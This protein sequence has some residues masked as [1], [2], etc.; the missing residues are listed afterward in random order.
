[1]VR[2][3]DCLGVG[4]RALR[5]HTGRSLLTTLG[6]VAGV[7]AVICTMSIGA[8]AE[9]EVAERL[10][11][12]GANLLMVTPGAA[13]PTGVR[14]E[15]GLQRNLTEADAAA[16]GAEIAG[17]E[18]AA[19]L[20]ARRLQIIA[21]NR[22]WSTLVAGVTPAYLAEREWSADEG[23]LFE[24]DDLESAARLAIIGSDVADALF[25]G[26]TAV[27][28]PIRI[29]A[30]PATV[31]AVLTRKGVGA[32]GRSQ[33]DVVFVPLSMARTRLLGEANG[34]RRNALDLIS[35]KLAD[36]TL[37]S[38]AKS[39]IETLLRQRHRLL[40]D[41]PDDFAVENPADVL[42][43][44]AGATRAL[45]WLLFG[46]AAVSLAVGGISLMNIMLVSVGERTREFG[47]RM[48]VGAGRRDLLLQMLVETISLALA[49]GLVGSL[50]GIAASL[51]IASQAEWRVSISTLA[52]LMAWG[53][54]GAVGLVFGLYP[55]YRASR[56]DPIEALR[57][58]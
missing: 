31:V 52:V 48:A 37:L 10:R 43:A 21:G 26:R 25:E 28:K 35:I 42:E 57:G 33:D 23:R 47:V 11:S 3:S 2:A 1:M 44:R 58:E 46:S 7:A 40:G 22:N 34:P 53:L 20:V 9:D 41:L 45:A 12:L 55:A 14:T 49:G 54:A 39:Q 50:V 24:T 15:A 16:I 30:V 19:P 4:W 29:G 17:V 18:G 36:P 51:A 32:A 13:K 38:D 8:G 6:I 5:A 27:G 56:L